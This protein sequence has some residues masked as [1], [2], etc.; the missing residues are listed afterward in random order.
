MNDNFSPKCAL[1]SVQALLESCM[2]CTR[3]RR[4]ANYSHSSLQVPSKKASCKKR[5]F[6]P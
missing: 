1:C 4:C 3:T 2:M 5:T 6:P